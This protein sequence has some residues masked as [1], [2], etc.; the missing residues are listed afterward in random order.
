VAGLREVQ[1][2]DVQLPETPENYALRRRARMDF[3]GARMDWN[4]RAGM[5]SGPGWILQ[6]EEVLARAFVAEDAA[7]GIGIEED[8]AGIQNDEIRN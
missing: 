3:G 2:G 7:A 8:E 5:N 6:G 1:L 4:A